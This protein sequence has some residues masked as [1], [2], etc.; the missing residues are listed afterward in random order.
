MMKVLV[1]YLAV[2]AGGAVGTVCRFAIGALCGRLF[3]SGFP[4]GTLLINVTGSFI[5]ACFLTLVGQRMQVSEA[6]RLAIAVGFVGG[7]TTFSTYMWES[8][9]LLQSGAAYKAIFNIAGSIVL[10]LL[11]VRL[12]IIVARKI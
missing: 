1:N 9:A 10:G 5:I 12:G 8:N 4:I 7:Y 3:G 6:A 2:A 11:A